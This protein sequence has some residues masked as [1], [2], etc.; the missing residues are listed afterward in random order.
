SSIR[1]HGVL[2][3]IIATENADGQLE[4]IDGQRRT[5]AAVEAGLATVP[6]IVTTRT[7][8]TARIIAQ[9]VVNDHRA[10]LTE[11]EHAAAFKQL[12]LF[13]VSADAIARKTNVP[14]KRVEL[15]INVAQS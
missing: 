4:V 9:L 15:A 10:S 14:R 5:I 8:D 6:V 1:Q 12:A 3:P 13:G 2:V 11:V 7:D